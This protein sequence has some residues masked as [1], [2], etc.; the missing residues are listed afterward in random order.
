M[1]EV[2]SKT[3]A[4]TIQSITTFSFIMSILQYKGSKVTLKNIFCFIVLILLI[5]VI[6]SEEYSTMNPII[7]FMSIVY[8]L[9]LLYKVTFSK[10]F[11]VAGIFMLVLFLA[12]MIV[13]ITFVP[14]ADANELRG[15]SLFLIC[16]NALT[17]I[18]VAL[19]IIIKKIRN[20]FIEIIKI[21]EKRKGIETIAFIILTILA[22]SIIFFAVSQ[23]YLLNKVFV[24]DI[25]GLLIFLLLAVIYLK[26]KYQKEK[27]INKY[28]QLFEYVKAFEEW[29]DTENMNIHESKNQL[30][31][32]RDMIKNNKKAKEYI[33]NIIKERVDIGGKHVEKLKY[34]PKGGLKGL[35]YYKIIHAENNNIEVF[36][37][38]AAASHEILENLDVEKNKVLCRLVGIFIDNA[39]EATKITTKKIISLEIYPNEVG[40]NIIISNT[41]IGNI[42]PNKLW[43]NGYS[44]K[45]ENRGKGLHLA[46]K[47]TEKNKEFLL[48]NR[49]INDYYI[50]KIILKK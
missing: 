48:D 44:T 27:I 37:D 5:L 3:V 41:Y 28:D 22:L 18:I 33:D 10:S 2:V 7:I 14:F 11:L 32:L 25:V 45:G 1:S 29:M 8:A 42:D 6:H 19:T 15:D 34:I 36:I 17:G 26:E 40:L 20:Y 47:T 4:A 43:E 49:I 50:Q 16:A 46:K 23:N 39:I 21:N 12:D 24:L 9:S 31:T 35:I 13:S 38:V 30:I